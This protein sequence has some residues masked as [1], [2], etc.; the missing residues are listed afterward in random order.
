[1]WKSW[2]PLRVKIF[3]WLALRR[4]HW[5]ADRRA[6]HCLEA[7]DR[8]YLCDKPLKQSTTSSLHVRSLGNSG[9][10]SYKCLASSSCKEPNPQSV[11]GAKYVS[12]L[13]AIIK[14]ASTHYLRLFLGR[15]GR[16]GMQGASETPLLRSL[17]CFKSSRGRRI[18]GSMLE[19][20]DCGH[21]SSVSI[22]RL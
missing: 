6:R 3:L 5:T 17:S 14:R 22:V 16:N 13:M 9:T 4:R 7:R 10:S 21:W 11:G 18:D 12:L 2:A 8:F 1:M 19:Q 15:C 20:L